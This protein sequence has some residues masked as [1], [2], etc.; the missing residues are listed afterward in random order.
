MNRLITQ[1]IGSGFGAGVFAGLIAGLAMLG[2]RSFLSAPSLQEVVMERMLLL[3]SAELFSTILQQFWTLSKVFAII[4]VTLLFAFIGGFLGLAYERRKDRLGFP[5]T[6][7]S[8]VRGAS[9]GLAMWLL[10]NFVLLPVLGD[11]FFG[12]NVPGDS[13]AFQVILFGG[14]MA[15]GL[16]LT[17][18]AD[19]NVWTWSAF[20][21]DAN[22]VSRRV[23]LTNVLG[24]VVV[25]AAA[26]SGLRFM[27]STAA[28]SAKKFAK[29]KEEPGE[30]PE[31]IT[32]V[33]LF[34]SVTK[35]LVDPEV[36]GSSWRLRVEGSMAR[37]FELTLPELRALP[38]VEQIVTLE[39]IENRVGGHLISN[40][41]WKGVRLIELLERGGV[42]SN[43]ARVVFRSAD[44]YDE[45]LSLDDAMRPEVLI[46]Y[47]MNGAPLKKEHG[48][49]ARV[50]V[51]GRYGMKM[52]K[53]LESIG[54]TQDPVYNG[55]WQKRGWDQDAFVKMT[56]QVFIPRSLDPIVLGTPAL[57]GGVALAGDQGVSRVEF[58]PDD[59]LTWHEALLQTAL[60]PFSWV[61]WTKEWAFNDA[62]GRT[63]VVRS[64]DGKGTQQISAETE[65]APAG[66]TGLHKRILYNIK[67]SAEG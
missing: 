2:L 36:S 26:G 24:L 3:I 53:W 37:P 60:S 49:P 47:D 15:F 4:G 65:A 7:P 46:A 54:T 14:M 10:T 42:S 5:T 32:P 58:S 8:L 22:G 39:C 27:V 64:Y 9:I 40:G 56:S 13:Q 30:M 1:L 20:S 18:I 59:G 35:N 43:V 33:G 61:L 57:V 41:L 67:T 48:F 28:D 52:P 34:Y 17:W 11:G 44:G 31:P 25:V 45:S 12:A 62:N 63:I 50:V 29:F 23:F 16:T 51:P 66:A 21:T 19:G 6:V 38:A 55:Y